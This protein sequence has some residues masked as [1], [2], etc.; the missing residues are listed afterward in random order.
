MSSGEGGLELDICGILRL[1]APMSADLPVPYA[2]S[3]CCACRVMWLDSCM[4][5]K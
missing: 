1:T 5:Y 3:D 4:E 2:S